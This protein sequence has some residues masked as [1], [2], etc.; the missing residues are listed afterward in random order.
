M[1][2]RKTENRYWPGTIVRIACDEGYRL[3]G[4]EVRR[5]REDGLWSWG[6]DPQCIKTLSYSLILSGVFIGVLLP[7]I[8]LIALFIFCWRRGNQVSEEPPALPPKTYKLN[9][10]GNVMNET[11]TPSKLEND[12]SL[13]SLSSSNRSYDID[14][15]FS[16]EEEND[17][18]E[19]EEEGLGIM[20]HLQKRTYSGNLGSTKAEI[21]N[22]SYL[23]S[24]RSI[25]LV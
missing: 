15:E 11:K 14:N 24:S 19:E 5:C 4:Y 1:N 16:D 12:N 20:K 21:N 13:K 3:I 22:D 23:P 25:T 6:V 9:Q 7:S 2:G 18:K 17:N 10:N 8:I